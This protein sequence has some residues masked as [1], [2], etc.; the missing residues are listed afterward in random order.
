MNK[1]EF[2]AR[3]G[4]GLSGLPR[5]EREERLAFYGEMIDDKMEE[6]LSEEEAV[7][8]AGDVDQILAQML[9]ENPVTETAG[10]AVKPRRRPN[11][12]AIVLILLGSPIWLALGVSVAAVL[13]SLYVSLWAVIVSL[14]A[15]FASLA[16]C[17]VA[18]V[19]AGIVLAAVGRGAAGIAILAAGVVCFGL[20]IPAF[21][22]CRAATVGTVILTKKMALWIKKRFIRKGEV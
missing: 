15:V 18:G 2:L 4:E 16:A 20:V 8:A 14:W 6:G 13:L 7:A 1:K 9:G 19:L 3:L 11:G 17:A 10:R 22:G 5:E 12:W 21:L